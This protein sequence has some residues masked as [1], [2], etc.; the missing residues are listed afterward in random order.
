[1]LICCGQKLRLRF[2]WVAIVLRSLV[3]FILSLPTLCFAQ[4]SGPWP[5][6]L[7]AYFWRGTEGSGNGSTGD[8]ANS[9]FGGRWQ[10]HAGSPPIWEWLPAWDGDT[11][12]VGHTFIS[13]D[14]V[15]P[16]SITG[17]SHALPNSSIQFQVYATISGGTFDV[18][19]AGI[20]TTSI[21]NNFPQRFPVTFIDTTFSANNSIA[22]LASQDTLAF[23]GA[24]LN[25]PQINL[26]A[27]YSLGFWQPPPAGVAIM[28]FSDGA[29]ISGGVAEVTANFGENGPSLVRVNDSEI[30]L[31]G[32]SVS[33]P[34]GPKGHGEMLLTGGSIANLEQFL[35]IGSEGNAFLIV[36]ESSQVNA[37]DAYVNVGESGIGDLYITG[38]STLEAHD[39]NVGV[40]EL[41]NVSVDEGSLL[42]SVNAKFGEIA[43]HEGT[44]NLE[45]GGLMQT[46]ELVL[47]AHGRGYAYV[48][49][50]GTLNVNDKLVVGEH[51]Q[52]QLLVL[53]GGSA[54]AASAALGEHAGSIGT[55]TVTDV[56]S[57]LTIQSDPLVG[58][59]G[60]GSLNVENGGTLAVTGAKIILG[61]ESDG[62][63]ALT[64]STA[65]NLSFTGE[66]IVGAFGSGVFALQA[67]AVY[68]GSSVIVGEEAD[69]IG[70]LNIELGSHLQVTSELIVGAHGNANFNLR[71]GSML[72]TQETI[73]GEHLTA[74]AL[75]SVD[76]ASA[77]N[78]NE[79]IIGDSGVV[80]MQVHAGAELHAHEIMVSEHVGSYSQ[81]E[82]VGE[83]TS[84]HTDGLFLGG[85]NLHA[86]GTAEVVVSDQAEL[87]VEHELIVWNA[88]DLRIPGGKVTVG[89]QADT[90]LDSSLLVNNHGTL[91][92]LGTVEA[93]VFNASGRLAPGHHSEVGALHVV[94]D[95]E[96]QVD[97]TLEFEIASGLDY[98]ALDVSGTV[99][100][101]GKLEVHLLGGAALTEGLQF[102]VIQAENISGEFEEMHLPELSSGLAWDSS[103]LYSEGILRVATAQ[104]EVVGSYFYHASF[105]GS[106]TPPESRIDSSK[107]VVREGTGP[108][109][110]SFNNLTNTAQGINGVVLDIVGL[111]NPANLNA[112]DFVFQVSPQGAF[113]E[114]ANPP[115][116]WSP[117]PVPSSISVTPGTPARLTILWPNQ[118]VMNRWLRVTLKTTPNTGLLEDQVYYLGHLLGETTGTSNGI[119][120]IAFAD[121]T[122]IRSAVG[123][124]VDASSVSD[125]DKNGTVSFSDISSMRSS[126]GNQ[127][128]QVTVP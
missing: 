55:A 94:G 69:G 19:D 27:S 12:L 36:D 124:N 13:P 96:Q 103:D 86:G 3:V 17:G 79:L 64:I 90:A 50:G 112:S 34:S 10:T 1:M 45:N 91:G 6:Y 61:E 119:L 62:H 57:T 118:S 51:G 63:G 9:W 20:S 67:G 84:V 111:A 37:N 85:S 25:A 126:V 73:I 75:V 71:N 122:P 98:D 113:Q 101:A 59:H 42:S 26:D 32:M 21:S 15:P 44:I 24:T 4:T 58:V 115:A 53:G 97:A 93:N 23:T 56:G 66:I 76:T 123:Q 128:R 104:P 100:L 2:S 127:L 72:T 28:E 29:R 31:L 109:T 125:I 77:W 70:D 105:G 52:G 22:A 108:Q 99:L 121:I 114:S 48:R 7:N 120:T 11:L 49:N 116:A 81:L 60:I 46:D 41:G 82:I 18:H 89:D 54:T 14:A 117:G 78:T 95:Y 106:G 47:G 5:P 38:G 92:G 16:F 80:I 83:N 68:T 87:L 39:L 74:A 107:T 102:Q 40:H 33:G 8:W 43:G 88:A 110:L 65:G 30:D 35:L